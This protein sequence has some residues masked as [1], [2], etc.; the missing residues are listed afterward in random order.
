MAGR[1]RWIASL[2]AVAGFLG[3]ATMPGLLLSDWFESAIGQNFG[4]EGNAAVAATFE[5]MWGPMVFVGPGL[6]CLVIA[7]PLAALAL[8]RAG[9]APWWGIVAAVAGIAALAVSNLSAP[10]AAVAILA[11]LGVAAA[12]VRATRDSVDVAPATP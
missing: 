2:A 5:A 6:P 12:F 1:G 11:H 7:L 9:R 8:W 3:L 10:G 4:T